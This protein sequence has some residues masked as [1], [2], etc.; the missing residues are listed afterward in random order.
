MAS[1]GPSTSLK[2]KAVNTLM[3]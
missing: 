3:I 1:E 2:R